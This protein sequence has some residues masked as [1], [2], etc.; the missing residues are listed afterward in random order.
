MVILLVFSAGDNLLSQEQEHR[1]EKA[2]IFQEIYP[3]ISE[4]DLYCS[5]LVMDDDSLDLKIIGGEKD[6]EKTLFN[7][8]DTV[9]INKGKSDGLQEGMLFLILEVGPKIKDFGRIAL[10]RGKASV[11][12][13][14]ENRA[15]AKI[16]MFAVK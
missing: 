12:A 14:E 9:Y 16:E 10:K 3:I 4:S 13:L 7:E 11:L 5:F 2:K 15:S 1:I 8:A 6:Y